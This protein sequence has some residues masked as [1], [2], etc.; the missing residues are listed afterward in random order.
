MGIYDP[1]VRQFGWNGSTPSSNGYDSLFGNIISAFQQAQEA[2]VGP[3]KF[4]DLVMTDIDPSNSAYQGKTIEINFPDSTGDV[5]NMTTA[6]GTNVTLNPVKT[7]RRFLTLDQHPTYAFVIPDMDK[8]LAARPEELRRMFVDE[9]IKK[10]T[11]YVNRTLQRMIFNTVSTGV[12]ANDRIFGTGSLTSLLKAN[13]A[14]GSADQTAS[15]MSDAEW[16]GFAGKGNAP[17]DTD[18][19]TTH[20]LSIPV[21][22]QMWQNLTEAKAPTDD[23]QNMFLLVR[24]STFSKIITDT[25]W[26]AQTSVGEGIAAGVRASARINTT[27]GVNVDWDLDVPMETGTGGNAGKFRYH[28]ILF[29]RRAFAVAYRPLE[30][31]P[32]SVGVQASMAYYRGIPIRFMISYDPKQFTYIMTFDSLFGA[33]VYRPEFAV[34]SPSAWLTAK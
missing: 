28:N 25:Q 13:G 21:L 14:V 12:A 5:T 18:S 8:A 7:V 17:V 16:A 22:A 11:S 3:N 2:L 34:R 24:P 32:P 23:T 19:S 29:H 1:G 27:F 9:A 31:P 26:T 33:M 4:L 10:F 15:G 6:Y 20:I 30:L